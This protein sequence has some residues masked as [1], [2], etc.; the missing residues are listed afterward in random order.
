MSAREEALDELAGVFQMIAEEY[1]Q[2]GTPLPEDTTEIV[3][4]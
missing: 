3:N 2:R 4:A 1:A